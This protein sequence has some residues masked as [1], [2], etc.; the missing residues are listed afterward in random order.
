MTAAGTT[1][2]LYL[3]QDRSD[4]GV[5]TPP[6]PPDP[7]PSPVKVQQPVVVKAR[8]ADENPDGS[9]RDTSTE[10]LRPGND[11]GFRKI[12]EETKPPKEAAAPA[13][14]EEKKPAEAPAPPAEPPKE[15]VYAGKFKSVEELEKSYEESQK[16]MH[17]AFEEKAALERQAT[18]RAAEPPKP[19]VPDNPEAKAAEANRIVNEF[20]QDPIAFKQKL[21][22]QARQ[23]TMTALAAQQMTE[24]WRKANPD[25]VEHEIRVAFEAAQ[26]IQSDPEMA[27]NPAALFDKAT[28][29]F[30]QFT[31]KLRTEGAKEALTQETRVVPLVSSTTTPSTTEHPAKAPLSADEAYNLHMQFLK[32]QEKKSHR[33]LRR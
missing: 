15:R 29:N 14:A 2:D 22:E 31:G 33:G 11:L 8:M 24:N 10:A 20:V 28:A 30:R 9:I 5:S 4:A 6:A 23:E 16:A 32:E 17:R 26:L 25:L 18:A 21:V 12:D 3:N 13:P 7:A 19:V 27:K 1:S